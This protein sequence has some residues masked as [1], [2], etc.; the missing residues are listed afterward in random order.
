[1]PIVD[2]VQARCRTAVLSNTNPIHFQKSSDGTTILKKFSK[3][4]LSFQIGAVKPDPEIY[5]YVVRDLSV[6]PS[7]I[8]LIDDVAEN[9]KAAGQCGMVGILFE[10]V[11]KLEKDLRL[12][13]ILV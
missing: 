12:R 5:R 6:E 3:R 10:N 13:R 4:Y 1:L 11:S 8:V 9:V 2:A 7:T